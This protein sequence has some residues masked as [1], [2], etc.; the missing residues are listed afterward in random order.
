MSNA[1]SEIFVASKRLPLWLHLA[2]TDLQQTYKR[3]YVGLAWITFAF[4]LFIG[5]KVVIF[6]SFAPGEPGKFAVWLTIG[7]WVY[8]FVQFNILDGCNVFMSARAWILGTNL[9]LVGFVFQS[10]IRVLIKFILHSSIVIMVLLYVSWDL[11]PVAWWAILGFLV[12]MINAIWAQIF[13]GILCTRFRDIAHFIQSIMQVMFFITPIIYLPS[14][15]GKNAWILQWNPFTH[16]L[17][18]VRDPI[19]MYTIPVKSWIIVGFITVVGC[20]SSL[21]L[22]QLFRKRVPFWV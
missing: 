18:I 13:L 10:I 20:I 5:V 22:L 9:P 4:A 1:F 12:L 17:A 11:Q 7:F 14:Q 15:L 6:G 21:I 2:I 19:V 16:Y 3:S 8:T